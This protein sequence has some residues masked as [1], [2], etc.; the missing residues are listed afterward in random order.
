E[1]EPPVRLVHHLACTGGTVISRCIS[2]MP[3]VRLLSEVDPLSPLTHQNKFIPADLLGLAKLGSRPPDIETLL[4]IFREGVKVLHEDCRLRGLDLVLRAHSHSQFMHGPDIPPRPGLQ[5]IVATA[6]PV[7]SVV[8]V[9]DPLDSYLS[10]LKNGWE[11]F[12]PK[13]ID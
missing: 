12:T 10:L 13:G 1:I 8:T 3:N 9:R 6:F 5:E 11:H 4:Q 7:Q 2:A